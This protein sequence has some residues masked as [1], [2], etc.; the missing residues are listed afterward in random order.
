M[1]MT[2]IYRTLAIQLLHLKKKLLHWLHSNRLSLIKMKN[3]LALIAS[4]LQ[5][6]RQT[7]VSSIN[8]K[9]LGT[10]MSIE[11]VFQT[12]HLGITIDEC[13]KWDKHVR[14]L[15]QKL[16]RA[17]YQNIFNLFIYLFLIY[18]FLIHWHKK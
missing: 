4:N 2:Q 15:N 3:K 14:N 8:C 7:T 12:G 18:L 5:L 1:E 16:T 6:R 17:V 13:L 9:I 10:C 11:T